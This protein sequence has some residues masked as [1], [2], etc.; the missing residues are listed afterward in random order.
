MPIEP[1]TSKLKANLQK[2]ID[3]VRN[4]KFAGNAIPMFFVISKS[5]KL[6][7]PQQAKPG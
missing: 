7:N 4:I 3:M 6:N 2:D 1:T 5:K